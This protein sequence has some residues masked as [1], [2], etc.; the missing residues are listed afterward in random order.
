MESLRKKILLVEDED[1]IAMNE[2]RALEKYGYD[3]Q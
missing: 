3:S 2:K 1:I